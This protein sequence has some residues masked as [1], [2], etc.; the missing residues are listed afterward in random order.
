MGRRQTSWVY[1]PPESPWTIGIR[2]HTTGPAVMLYLDTSALIKLYVAEKGSRETRKRVRVEEHVATSRVAYPE[3][4]SALARRHREGALSSEGLRRAVSALD[5]DMGT[6]VIVEL[7]EGVARTAG[8]LAQRHAL[9]AFDAIHLASAIE[10]GHLVGL[11]PAFLT[12][13]ARQF[14]AAASLGLQS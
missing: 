1:Q 2:C 10:L 4:R 3:A 13:D 11:P 8:D 14:Q 9:R 7:L 12:F 6:F 5:R